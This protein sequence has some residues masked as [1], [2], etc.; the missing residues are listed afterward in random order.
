VT[1]TLVAVTRSPHHYSPA[2]AP[3]ASF[4][5]VNR[6]VRALNQRQVVHVRD[7]DG[8]VDGR[9]GSMSDLAIYRLWRR[10]SGEKPVYGEQ[11]RESKSASRRSRCVISPVSKC[12]GPEGPSCDF[13]TVEPGLLGINEVHDWVSASTAYSRECLIMADPGRSSSLEEELSTSP[14]RRMFLVESRRVA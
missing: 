5:P 2:A 12:E 1:F 13:G 11:S 10:V 6:K 7:A 3:A 4:K 9:K 8:Q 14:P